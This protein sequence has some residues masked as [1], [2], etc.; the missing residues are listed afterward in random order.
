MVAASPAALHAVH[1]PRTEGLVSTEFLIELGGDRTPE[2]LRLT[3]LKAKG[4]RMAHDL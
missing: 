2:L 1:G 3:Y 4:G